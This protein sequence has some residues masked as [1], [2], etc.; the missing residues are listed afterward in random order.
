MLFIYV[1]CI[2]YCGIVLQCIVQELRDVGDNPRGLKVHSTFVRRISRRCGP[3]PQTIEMAVVELF[4]IID[5]GDRLRYIKIMEEEYSKW[6]HKT[7][8][9][10]KTR[11]VN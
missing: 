4:R 10:T 7:I 6:T 11:A 1:C 3:N 8:L 5:E 9:Q 2:Y